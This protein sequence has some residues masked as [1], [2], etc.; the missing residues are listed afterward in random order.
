MSKP[1]ENL[2]L[3]PRD[4]M[5][6]YIAYARKYVKPKLTPEACQVIQE[7]YMDL[8]SSHHSADATPMTT[9]QL[10]SLIRLTQ[11]RA[12]LSLRSEATAEDANEVIEIMKLSMVDTFTDDIGGL[13]ISRSCHGSGMDKYCFLF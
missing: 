12:K 3:L 13:D 7:F 1:G 11:A 2:D 8:R 6:K 4:L 10:E 9:R 5:K